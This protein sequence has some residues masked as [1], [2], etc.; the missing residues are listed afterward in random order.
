MNETVKNYVV[1]PLIIGVI[2]FVLVFIVSTLAG[3]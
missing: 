2:A 1:L 3:A